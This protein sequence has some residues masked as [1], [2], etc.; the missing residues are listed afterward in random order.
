MGKSISAQCKDCD[1]K[2]TFNY[3]GNKLNFQINC[4]VPSINIKTGQF[5]NINYVS[6]KNNANYK[7]YSTKELKGDNQNCNTLN[8]FDLKLNTK[9]NYCPKC[10]KNALD[11]NVIAYSD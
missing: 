11:F 3:G 10:K 2:T 9:N 4:P 7:F 5:E 1:F 8:Y 6:E